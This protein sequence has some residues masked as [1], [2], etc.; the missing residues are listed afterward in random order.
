MTD[1]I[2]KWTHTYQALSQAFLVFA[3]YQPAYDEL[4]AEHDVLYAGPDPDAVSDDDKKTLAELGWEPEPQYNC[5][6]Y[7]T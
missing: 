6:R 7:F 5:F 4:A 3:R 2:D 1:K